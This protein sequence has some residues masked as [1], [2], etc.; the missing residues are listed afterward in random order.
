[1]E[2]TLIEPLIT[3]MDPIEPR[4]V[5]LPRNGPKPGQSVA[6]WLAAKSRAEEAALEKERWKAMHNK[7]GGQ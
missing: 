2:A 7:K 4:I 3:S 1:M 6:A 5:R